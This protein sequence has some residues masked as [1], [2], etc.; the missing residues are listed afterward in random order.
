MAVELRFQRLG[1]HRRPFYHLVATDSRKPL[2]GEV[3]ERL[4]YYDPAQEPSLVNLKEDRVAYWYGKGAKLSHAVGTVLKK[5]KIA[6]TRDG[7]KTK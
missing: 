3:L 2:C 1:T 5:K 6:L 7:A 4:G